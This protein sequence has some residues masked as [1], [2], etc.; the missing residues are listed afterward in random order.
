MVRGA[1]LERGWT[2]RELA[3][4]IDGGVDAN[5]ISRYEKGTNRPNRA[6]FQR[7]IEV[8]RLDPVAARAAWTIPATATT[9]GARTPQPAVFIGPQDWDP[10]YAYAVRDL[11]RA[12][13]YI[14]GAD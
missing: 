9:G 13:H 2:Q 14:E 7:M 5:Q 10:G 8:L 3:E 12:H 11:E 1:R 6:R 4:R